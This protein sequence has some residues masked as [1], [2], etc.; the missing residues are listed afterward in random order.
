MEIIEKKNKLHIPY[1][2][3][4]HIERVY[5]YFTNTDLYQVMHQRFMW[6]FRCSMGI[7]KLDS[8]GSEFEFKW[9]PNIT[10][11]FRIVDVINTPHEKSINCYY[12]NVIPTEF[13]YHLIY[14]F[15]YS[16][17]EKKTYFSYDL[18]F[19]TIQAL[20]Y[21]QSV[22]DAQ[23]NVQLFTDIENHLKITPYLLEQ[24]ESV[25]LSENIDNIWNVISNWKLFRESVPLIA[26]SVEYDKCNIEGAMIVMRFNDDR[27]YNLA[28]RKCWRDVLSG[29]YVLEMLWSKPATPRHYIVLNVQELLGKCIVLFK[30]IF[31]EAVGASE[32]ASLGRMKIEILK[33][34]K[35]SFIRKNRQM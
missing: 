6:E 20:S 7:N 17:V 35:K 2:F 8:L 33:M 4:E 15:H 18:I 26:D 22:F 32:L 5:Y 31:I 19:N 11:H 24:E 3:N 10:A 13:K 27:E 1:V 25:I 9:R 16:T 29:E 30:H 14:R 12:F 28:V 23:E 34:L 21:F